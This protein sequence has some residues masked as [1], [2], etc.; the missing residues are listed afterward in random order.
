[1]PCWLPSSTLFVA[2]A[3]VVLVVPKSY[4][5]KLTMI[6]YGPLGHILLSVTIPCRERKLIAR[7]VNSLLTYKS[8]QLKSCSLGEAY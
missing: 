4:I 2:L 7:L 6:V 1:M 5:C 8:M 3:L